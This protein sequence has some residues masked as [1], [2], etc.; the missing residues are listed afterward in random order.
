[1]GWGDGMKRVCKG[2]TSTGSIFRAAVGWERTSLT[3]V[4]VEGVVP[5]G[6]EE[7]WGVVEGGVVL[8]DWM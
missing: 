8:R 1:M 5:D 3:S 6:G 2:A 7:G 4:V